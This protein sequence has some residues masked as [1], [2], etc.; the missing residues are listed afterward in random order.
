MTP[1]LTNRSSLRTIVA[2]CLTV[3]FGFH[4]V[5]AQPKKPLRFGFLDYAFT[6]VSVEDTKVAINLYIQKLL[7]ETHFEPNTIVYQNFDNLYRAVREQTVEMASLSGTDF[8]KIAPDSL[9]VPSFTKSYEDGAIYDTYVLLVHKDNATTSLKDLRN[10][11]IRLDKKIDL[12]SIWLNVMLAENNLPEATSFFKKITYDDRPAQSV[13]AVFFKQSEACVVTRR[14]FQ[15]LSELNP[16]I[17]KNLV[18]I[19]ESPQY[20]PGILCFH[21]KLPPL[22]QEILYHAALSFGDSQEGKQVL[23]LFKTREVVP[24]K[25]DFL[26]TIVNLLSRYELYYGRHQSKP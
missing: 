18:P 16:Q 17:S 7:G 1:S 13:L 23:N 20:I 10:T 11:A 22:D 5:Q 21:A 14:V 4:T 8:L 24:F 3:G 19:L 12:I 25:Y 6:D 26:E 2:F 9:L 15:V